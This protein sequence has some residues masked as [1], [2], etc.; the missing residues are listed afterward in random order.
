MRAAV[1]ALA[2]GLLTGGCT[3]T[4]DPPPPAT[5]PVDVPAAPSAA[6]AARAACTR[7][8]G[9]LPDELDPGVRRR[10]VTDA[11]RAAAWGDPAIVL[12]CGVAQ[13]E[14]S[15]DPVL[16]GP[17]E[18]TEFVSFTVRDTGSAQLWTARERTVAVSVSV[19]DAY[20]GQVLV[21][22]T[23]PVLAAL[24]AAPGATES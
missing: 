23:G 20:D 12:V 13:P 1:V 5:G 6:P 24:P 16:I 9:D 17:P 14:T 3:S 2:A 15:S 21:P 7:L 10:P 4:P 19:P 22:L 18:G 8:L 11:T